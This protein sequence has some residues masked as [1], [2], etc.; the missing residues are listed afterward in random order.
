MT[1]GRVIIELTES[2][3]VYDYHQLKE[4]VTHCRRLGFQIAIDDLGEGFSSLRLWSEVRPDFVKID[5]HFIQEIQLDPMKRQFVRSIQEI[6]QQSGCKVIAEGTPSQLKAS[7]GSGRLHV[8]LLDP[9]QR[10][11][12]AGVGLERQAGAVVAPRVAR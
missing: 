10:P 12:Q 11:E 2:H 5:M 1:S 7:V 6:A 3:P 8:R 9:E 4:A